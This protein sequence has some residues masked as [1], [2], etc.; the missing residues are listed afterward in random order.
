MPI[1]YLGYNIPLLLSNGTVK[2][3]KD[4]RDDDILV[5]IYSET[6]KILNIKYVSND[7]YRIIPRY[8]SSF[9]IGCNHNLITI[10]QKTNDVKSYKVSEMNKSSLSIMKMN[11]DFNYINIKIDPYFLGIWLGSELNEF[12]ININKIDKCIY[13]Y[14][15]SMIDKLN[16]SYCNIL[17]DELIIT[18]NRIIDYFKM[19]DLFDKKYIPEDYK[20]NKSVFRLRLLAGILDIRGIYNVL[21]E[22]FEVSGGEELIKD[23]NFI[24]QSL[25]LYTNL[26][27]KN[28]NIWR[29]IILGENLKD[30]PM[31]TSNRVLLLSKSIIVDFKIAPIFDRNCVK[32]EVSSDTIVLEDF[33][34]I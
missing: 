17:N 20:Y 22:Y 18:D 33:T 6:V 34:V 31:I 32:I 12:K 9:V 10:S 15:L 19:L 27:K 1:K 14:I 30:I 26:Y 23:I 7:M 3:A 24:A 25:G 21:N 28:G 16:L 13:N 8:G 29:I 2:L 4:I 11:I 5:G